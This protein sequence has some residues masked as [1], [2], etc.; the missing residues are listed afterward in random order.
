MGGVAAPHSSSARLRPLVRT[1]SVA[2]SLCCGQYTYRIY[3]PASDK[4]RRRP[5]APDDAARDR[6]LIQ[7]GFRAVTRLAEKLDPTTE[8]YQFELPPRL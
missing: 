2:R 4:R 5:R 7:D 6:A 3:S 8:R 1:T